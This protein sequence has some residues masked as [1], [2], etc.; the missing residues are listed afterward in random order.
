MASNAH[1]FE[2]DGLSPLSAVAFSL[3]ASRRHLFLTENITPPITTRVACVNAQM[4]YRRIS[5]LSEN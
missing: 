4:K 3:R 5:K 2:I 1:L